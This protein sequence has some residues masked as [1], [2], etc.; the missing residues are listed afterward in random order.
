MAESILL[1]QTSDEL[2][3]EDGE[4]ILLE[5]SETGAGTMTIANN[6]TGDGYLTYPIKP[7]RR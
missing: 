5:D 4:N 3:T 1:T 7:I 2:T 6:L